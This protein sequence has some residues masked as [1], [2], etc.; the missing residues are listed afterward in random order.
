MSWRLVLFALGGAAL[1]F[2]YQRVVG[3][4]SGSCPLTSNAWVTTLYGAL[5]GVLTSGGWR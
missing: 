1:G 3:C 2:V 4:R 5:V